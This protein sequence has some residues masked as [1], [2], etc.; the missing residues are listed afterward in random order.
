MPFEKL[1]Q[2]QMLKFQ[3]FMKNYGTATALFSL[4]VENKTKF[5]K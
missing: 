1:S 3:S 4:N 2:S 5:L